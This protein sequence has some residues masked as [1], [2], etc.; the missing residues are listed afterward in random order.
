MV[1][2]TADAPTKDTWTD[3]L[4]AQAL[5][6][7]A[8]ATEKWEWLIQSPDPAVRITKHAEHT[9][10]KQEIY[11]RERIVAG[12]FQQRLFL[13]LPRTAKI[14]IFVLFEAAKLFEQK[15]S[16]RIGRPTLRT[17]P[18]LA[19]GACAPSSDPTLHQFRQQPFEW[20]VPLASEYQDEFGEEGQGQEEEFADTVAPCADG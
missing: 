10:S 13:T 3:V 12:S 17:H 9:G 20:V 11:R 16:P 7:I 14:E 5:G 6:C 18:P 8:R 1:L 2:L 15:Q 19:A 4:P